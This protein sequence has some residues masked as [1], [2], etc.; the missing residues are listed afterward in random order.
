[1]PFRSKFMQINPKKC[2]FFSFVLKKKGKKKKEKK[3]GGGGGGS[4]RARKCQKLFG[5]SN[6]L[7][8]F[9]VLKTVSFEPFLTCF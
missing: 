5:F 7:A 9:T 2:D 1:M 8:C 3:R 4:L 6:L